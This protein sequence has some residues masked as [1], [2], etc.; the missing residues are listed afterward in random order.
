MSL[1]SQE[2]NHTQARNLALNFFYEGSKRL[3]VC[4]KAFTTKTNAL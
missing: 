3:H 2:K 1:N 4:C